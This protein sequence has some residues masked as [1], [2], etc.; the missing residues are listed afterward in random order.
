MR[1]GSVW[2]LCFLPQELF[3]LVVV[4]ALVQYTS[5]HYHTPQ[6]IT[7]VLCNS[8]NKPN[9]R[10]HRR[11]SGLCSCGQ[12]SSECLCPF[13]VFIYRIIA[14]SEIVR[15]KGKCIC[16]SDAVRSNEQCHQVVLP[17]VESALLPASVRIPAP[18]SLAS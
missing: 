7:W 2:V 17:E 1:G 14:R 8:F 11:H 10:G 4:L 6:A 9:V 13:V 15:S 5:S 12:L 16:N 18:H 3:P